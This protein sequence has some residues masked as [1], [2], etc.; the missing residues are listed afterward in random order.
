MAFLRKLRPKGCL[1]VV[2]ACVDMGLDIHYYYFDKR[3]LSSNHYHR[4][5]RRDAAF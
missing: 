1:H 3:T 2:D 4:R 5:D